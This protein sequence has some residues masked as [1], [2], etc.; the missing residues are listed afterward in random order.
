[1][2]KFKLSPAEA[3]SAIEMYRSKYLLHGVAQYIEHTLTML[4][5]ITEK[6]V[7]SENKHQVFVLVEIL[8][9]MQVSASLDIEKFLDLDTE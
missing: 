2:K 6:M 4:D 9:D 1:M 5:I 7:K 3:S 8:R